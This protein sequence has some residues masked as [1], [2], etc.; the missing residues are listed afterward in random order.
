MRKEEKKK[1]YVLTPEE[2]LEK[3]LKNIKKPLMTDLQQRKNYKSTKLRKIV[4]KKK[5]YSFPL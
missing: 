1:M 4:K 3:E 5:K 2:K